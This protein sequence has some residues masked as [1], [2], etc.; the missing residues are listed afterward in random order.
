MKEIYEFIVPAVPRIIS[1]GLV[2]Q[3]FSH[4]TDFILDESIQSTDVNSELSTSYK[5]TSDRIGYAGLT[6]IFSQFVDL[7][8]KYI[9][10]KILEEISK[11]PQDFR[12][13]QDELNSYILL[14]IEKAL[15]QMTQMGL[16]DNRM[17]LI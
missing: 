14:G 10:E 17:E 11:T 9:R 16:L 2:D 6:D 3:L 13:Q 1:Q 5:T 8:M 7:S 4:S 15:I 12:I